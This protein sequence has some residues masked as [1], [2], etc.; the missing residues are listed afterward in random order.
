MNI[1]IIGASGFIGGAVAAEAHRVGHR[2][3]GFS[4][5]DR[6]SGGAITEWR[7]SGEEYDLSGLDVVI[8]LAGYPIDC[9]WTEKRKE[10]F[11]RSRVGVTE[12]LVSS[13]ERMPA[14]ERPATLLNGSAVGIYGDAGEERLPEIA[15]HGEGYLAELTEQW[16]DAAKPAETL[17]VRVC[18]MR[19]GFVLGKGGAAY[20]KLEM[21]FKLG[22]GGKLGDGQQWMPWIHLEDIARAF[23]HAAE[24]QDLS[25]AVNLAAPEAERNVDFTRKLAKALSRPAFFAVPGFAL[26]LVLGGF[27]EFLLGGQRVVPAALVESGF[28]FKYPT[29]ER[30]LEDL[31]G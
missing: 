16:E 23:V 1:G 18:L 17:G 27:G 13:I 20:E 3:V 9:R 15:A 14:D 31:A 7:R 6:E 28:A 26:K 5:S 4:R 10:L 21:V 2:V 30:A 25:G 29:L 11:Y 12:K 19:V 22:L 8:N 24:T